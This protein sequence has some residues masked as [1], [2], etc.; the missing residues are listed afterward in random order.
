MDLKV[1]SI[2][3]KVNLKTF[4]APILFSAI[5]IVI[6][7]VNFRGYGYRVYPWIVAIFGLCTLLFYV[8]AIW[9]D[10]QKIM[11]ISTNSDINVNYARAKKNVWKWYWR[12]CSWT[13]TIFTWFMLGILSVRNSMTFVL[14]MGSLVYG[15]VIMGIS[16]VLAKKLNVIEENYEDKKDIQDAAEDDENWIFGMIYYN[17]KDK[18]YM[19]QTRFGMGTT[20]NLA[21]PAGLLTE[22]LGLLAFLSIPIIC[23]WMIMLEFTPLEVKVENETIICEQLSVKYEIPLEEIVE[24]EVITELPKLIKVNGNGMENQL[25][26]TFEVYREGMFE[27]FLNPENELFLYVVTEDKRYYLGG[28]EDAMTKEVIEILGTR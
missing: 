2:P 22:L 17:K 4:F 16:I 28:T 27:V 26:G 15:L 8:T 3:S 14:I 9:T 18:H 25:S 10:R 20:V 13:N 7:F 12:V 5:P 1:I 23:I 21:H 19:T 24:Y 6:A 11:V